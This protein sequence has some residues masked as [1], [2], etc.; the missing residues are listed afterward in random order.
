LRLGVYS[1]RAAIQEVCDL[2]TFQEKVRIDADF[3][4]NRPIASV[5]PQTKR[6]MPIKIDALYQEGSA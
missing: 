1:D 2:F 4:S 6:R 5:N 3:T